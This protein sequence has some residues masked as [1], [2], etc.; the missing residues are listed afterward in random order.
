M[1]KNTLVMLGGFVIAGAIIFLLMAA[2]PGSSGV[3]LTL[4]DLKENQEKHKDDF[5]T[6]EGLLVEDTIEWNADKIKLNFDV[7]DNENNK[8][9]VVYNGV[10]PDNFSDG[11]IVIM[12]G[13][14]GKEDHFEAESIKTRCP[15]KYEGEDMK[16][17]D[18]DTH[19]DKLNKKP[20]E[21]AAGQPSK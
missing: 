13:Y 15:S 21:P 5:V 12:Q 8:M 4:K 11:V 19:K 1:K 20:E 10:K 6:F 2:T 3:E 7:N 17:Y 18:P 16:N 9:H 14:L